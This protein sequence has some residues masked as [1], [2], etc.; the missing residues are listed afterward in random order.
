MENFL[1]LSFFLKI[2]KITNL[3]FT[4]KIGEFSTKFSV[5]SK[6]PITNWKKWEISHRIFNFFPW[7]CCLL[8]FWVFNHKKKTLHEKFEPLSLFCSSIKMRIDF[9]FYQNRAKKKNF[10][11]AVVG[12]AQNLN[13]VSSRPRWSLFD[14]LN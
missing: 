9:L 14:N 5:F 1:K 7:K 4:G 6:K 8:S 10:L 11:I 12:E 13:F 3:V 2:G